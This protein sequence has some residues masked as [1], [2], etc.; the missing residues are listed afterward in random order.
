ES[1][2]LKDG[3][4]LPMEYLFFFLGA[5][6]CTHWL[7]DTVRRDEKGFILTGEDAGAE[8]GLETSVPGIFAAGDVRSGSIKRCATAVGEGATVVRFVHEHMTKMREQRRT[9]AGSA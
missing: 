1:V 5:A 7:P 6:P 4:T 9:A 3:E 2:T 8:G